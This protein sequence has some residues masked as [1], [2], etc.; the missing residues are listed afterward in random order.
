[1]DWKVLKMTFL[2]GNEMRSDD[3]WNLE[4]GDWR[5][6]RTTRSGQ[7]LKGAT[8]TA[9]KS[10]FYVQKFCF[11]ETSRM[12]KSYERG[13]ARQKEMTPLFQGEKGRG[14]FREMSS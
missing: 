6:T 8:A 9:V 11:R 5:G 1:M 10:R 7:R 2:R 14:A 13:G 3:G 12:D 4:C